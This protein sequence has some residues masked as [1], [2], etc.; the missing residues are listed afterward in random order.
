[1]EQ[2]C[3]FKLSQGLEHLCTED[4]RSLD[5]GMGTSSHRSSS[6]QLHR[7]GKGCKSRAETAKQVLILGNL[8]H[9]YSALLFSEE[10]ESHP[11]CHRGY[12]AGPPALALELEGW[13]WGYLAGSAVIV[14]SARTHI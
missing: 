2:L 8:P 10:A 9:P 1:M 11:K 14:T 3:H 6:L 5:S 12:D 13:S 4:P 7:A